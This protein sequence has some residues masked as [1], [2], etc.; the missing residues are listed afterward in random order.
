MEQPPLENSE[1]GLNFWIQDSTKM[2]EVVFGVE[3]LSTIE[4]FHLRKI[5]E[6]VVKMAERDNPRSNLAIINPRE[7]I[8]TRF[9]QELYGIDMYLLK[10]SP[11][12]EKDVEGF[13]EY[14]RR[15]RDQAHLI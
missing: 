13:Q 12:S 3:N 7:E 1:R 11:C 15:L 4:R 14:I 5:A 8:C 10:Q 9:L 2:L 6:D